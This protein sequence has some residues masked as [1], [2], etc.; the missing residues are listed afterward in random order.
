[1]RL[2]REPLGLSLVEWEHQATQG[3]DQY[4]RTLDLGYVFPFRNLSVKLTITERK[5]QTAPVSGNIVAYL[6][7]RQYIIILEP[8]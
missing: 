7:Q 4:V 1:M 3:R 5:F 2:V 6:R 8:A